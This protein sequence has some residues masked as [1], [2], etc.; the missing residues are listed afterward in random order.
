MNVTIQPLTVFQKVLSDKTLD[1][2]QI[3]PIQA[4]GEPPILIDGFLDYSTPR[5]IYETFNV[6]LENAA[7]LDINLDGIGYF[8]PDAQFQVMDSKGSGVL[9]GTTWAIQGR[10]MIYDDGLAL[11]HAHYLVQQKT[12]PLVSPQ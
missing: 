12:F 6:V 4:E 11:D 2:P 10:P 9:I 5:E 1:N 7:T 8:P 3:S